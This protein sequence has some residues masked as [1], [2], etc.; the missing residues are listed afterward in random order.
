M[1]PLKW[2]CCCKESLIVRIC[3]KD[4]V[5]FLFPRRTYI[6][7]WSVSNIYRKHMLLEVLMQ[8]SCIIYCISLTVTS[9]AKVLWHSNC[10]Y[11]K[12]CR[13]ECGIKR[14]DCTNCSKGK[15]ALG[16][17]YSTYSKD[18]DQPVCPPVFTRHSVDRQAPKASTDSKNWS[19]WMQAV[20]SELLGA[21][22]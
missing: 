7:E 5:L 17:A 14:V 22:V 9:W 1:L 13:M 16:H 18:Q 20:W 2:I 4:L 15:C 12:V 6:L 8:Y 21:H 19:D 10:Y 3:K 11:N